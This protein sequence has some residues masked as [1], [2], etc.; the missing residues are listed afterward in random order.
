MKWMALWTGMTLTVA[1]PVSGQ[2]QVRLADS[3]RA[4]YSELQ[5]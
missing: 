2:V 3:V 5:D 4:T 1:A